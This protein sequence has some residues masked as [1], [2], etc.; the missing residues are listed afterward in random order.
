[1]GT[2]DKEK[3]K[4]FYD[5]GQISQIRL[6]LEDSNS[7]VLNKKLIISKTHFKD[8]V[9]LFYEKHFYQDD[10]KIIEY[11]SNNEMDSYFEIE[12][13]ADYRISK[14]FSPQ[15]KMFSREKIEY[16]NQGKAITEEQLIYN[17]DGTKTEYKIKL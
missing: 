4:F 3:I 5:D 17:A 9:T 6:L 13:T 2:N 10:K 15:G 1:M 16:N 7:Q 8:F 12:K 14:G 11:Y